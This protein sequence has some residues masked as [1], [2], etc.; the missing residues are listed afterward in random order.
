MIAFWI[1]FIEQNWR[2]LLGILGVNKNSEL[3][4]IERRS[5]WVGFT[6]V[7][8]IFEM[9]EQKDAIFVLWMK[10]NSISCLLFLRL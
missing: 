9:Y 1:H 5:F 6:L 4:E 2:R 10:K 8:P 7:G 3:I